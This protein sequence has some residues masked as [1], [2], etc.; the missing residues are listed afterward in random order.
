MKH[1]FI[2]N[3]VAGKK[4]PT[5]FITQE[6]ERIGSDL[7][8][9][10]YVTQQSGDA[11][12]YVKKSVATKTQP[13]RIYAC[14]GDGTLNEVVNGAMGVSDVSVACYPSGSGNDFAK[15]FG[16][17]E[18]FMDLSRLIHGTTQ[19]V[20]AMKVNDRYTINI[21]NLGFDAFVADNMIKFKNKPLVSGKMAYQLAILYSLLFR[22]KHQCHVRV[23]D[24]VVFDAH[25]LLC[26]IANGVCYG[27]GYYCAPRAK[28][29]DG[30]LDFCLVKSLSRLTFIGLIDK[31][32]KGLHLEDPK[33]Q[34][35][36]QFSNAKMVEI[37]SNHDILYCM[38]GEVARAKKIHIEIVPKSIYFV[39]PR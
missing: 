32:K 14:G 22:M 26:S 21:C 37:E 25:L 1:L 27:G 35:Y 38:D 2:I 23:D 20:D 10:I 16:S 17:L 4:N 39:I 24:Q 28:V 7:D 33:I 36:I 6:L 13:L 31:Y 29:D 18:D 15:N 19:L 9:E 11:Y 8:Y 5:D 30:L 3:P 12:D 34:K